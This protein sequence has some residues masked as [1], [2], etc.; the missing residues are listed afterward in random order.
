MTNMHVVNTSKIFG[1]KILMDTNLL[2][3]YLI[4]LYDVELIEKHKRTKGKYYKEDFVL[5]D[6]ILK[7]YSKIITTPHIL[8][9]ISNLAAQIDETTKMKLFSL[10][11]IKFMLLEEIFEPFIEIVGNYEFE[12]YGLTDSAFC[13]LAIKNDFVVLTDDFKFSGQLEKKHVETI[14]INHLRKHIY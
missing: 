1:K 6:N 14:N 13:S 3:V 4:G 9:E 10:F 2:L 12:K 8:T 5:I 11:S 7:R